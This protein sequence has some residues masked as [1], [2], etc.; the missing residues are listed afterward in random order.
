MYQ[1]RKKG[2]LLKQSPFWIFQQEKLTFE[3]LESIRATV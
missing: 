1:P 3:L 2:L